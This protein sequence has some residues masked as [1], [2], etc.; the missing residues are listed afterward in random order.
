MSAKSK[1]FLLKINVIGKIKIN[2]YFF[3]KFLVFEIFVKI[4]VYIY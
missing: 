2:V 1:K 4:N 3:Y